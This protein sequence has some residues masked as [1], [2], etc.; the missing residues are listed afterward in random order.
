MKLSVVGKSL[1]RVDVLEKVTGKAV[2]CDEIKLPR[3]L[4]AKLLRSPL[5]HA[6]ILRV[7]TSKARKIPGVKV[8]LTSEN[9]PRKRYGVTVFDQTIL[10]VDVVRYAGE[11]IA[12]IAAESIEAAE[13]AIELI[14]V[15]YEELPAI[16]DPEEA[17]NTNPPVIIH[18]D[19]FKYSKTA[20]E[21][22][23][24]CL[25]SDRSNVN[26]HYKLRKG[27]IERGFREADFVL[28][29]KFTSAMVQHC[30]IEPHV[31]V[32]QVDDHGN[33]TVYTGR[34]MIHRAKHQLSD[35]FDIIPSKVRIISPYIGGG[36]GNKI[37]LTPSCEAALLALKARR[38]V[39]LILTRE[40][41]FT[42]TSTR[43]SMVVYLKD[44]VRKDG[45]L[46]AREMKAIINSGAYSQSSGVCALTCVAGAMGHYKI[47]HIKF[48]GYAVYTNQ[49]VCGALRGLHAHLPTMAAECHMDLIA[50]G[51]GVGPVEIRK[52]NLLREGEENYCGEIVHSIGASQCLDKAAEFIG[53]DVRQALKGPWRTGKGI[54]VANHFSRSSSSAAIVKMHEDG[55]IEV[56]H[57]A[58]E[59]GQGC[60]TVV[61]QIAAEEFGVSI[62]SVKVVFMDTAV[63]P[64][65]HGSVG[66][67]TTYTTGNAVRLACQDAKQIL[68]KL[69]AEILEVS[70]QD[71]ETKNGR[72]YAKSAPGRV[73]MV[74]AL[75]RPGGCLSQGGEIIGRAT[76]IQDSA[77]R[78]HETGQIEPELAKA[79]KR[80][81]GF[82]TYGAHAADVAVNMETGEV[83]VLRFGSAL[84]MG[85][86]INQKMC[87]Q[88]MEGG[89]GMGI[90]TSLY[91][92]MRLD[93]GVVTNPNFTDYRIP[94]AD[95]M[96]LVGNVKSSIV[97]APHKDG[98]F[99][100]KG[101]GEGA[102]MPTPPAIA[103]AIYDVTGVMM[104]SIPITPEKL[105]KALREQK[106]IGE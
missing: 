59:L 6:K 99:G 98:P 67:R 3:M 72:V 55:M 81:M 75:F 18:P 24:P 51:V 34:Q 94:T 68:F 4:H 85:E 45:I 9:A 100:A 103:N 76:F 80:W 16:F 56:R 48:D 30:P 73:L 69:A 91:E 39:K 106:L 101:M 21:E 10:A 89:M 5:P 47:P 50:K 60:N 13:E 2:Y 74:S 90:A 52:K 61:A 41:V 11:P 78:D 37:V 32:A 87:E 20:H 17:M 58:N 92:E 62:E 84:D 57:S 93:R 14:E 8:V 64:F 38:P 46:V 26:Y 86:P 49:P 63:T 96:P 43:G 44:G 97:S 33:L 29:N 22:Y 27:D 35:L 71:L 25:D 40:E 54:A 70:P 79:G 83:K 77:L 95:E 65:D 42:S 66:S 104:M 28:E 88:Q 31:A 36:F 15:E 7:D 102:M 19:L 12:A 23:R 53:T 1:T 105:L 82:Y